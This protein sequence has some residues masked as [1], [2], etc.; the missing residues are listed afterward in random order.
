MARRRSTV[1]QRGIGRR[2]LL[3]RGLPAGVGLAA[4]LIAACGG[5]TKDSGGQASGGGT[6]TTGSATTTAEQPR[7]GGTLR[8]GWT[9]AYTDV[10]DPHVSLSQAGFIFS[11][12]GNNALRMNGEGTEVAGELIEKW[13]VPGDGTEM[14]LK[15][16]QG[17]K[18]HDKPPVSGRGFDA[19]DVAFNLMRI[20]GKVNPSEAARF[21]RRQTVE[22]MAKAEAVDPATV[23]VTFDR[24]VS[25]FLS[26]LADIRNQMIP[27]DFLDKG[28]KLEDGGALIGTGPFVIDSFKGDTRLEFKRNPNYWKP[29][30]PYVDGVVWQI[31]P[32]SLSLYTSFGKGDLDYTGYPLPT[33]TDRELIKRT[34]P[35]AREE[36]YISPSWNHFRFNATKKPFDD[37]RV[38]RAIHLALNYKTLSEPYY[39]DGYWDYTGLCPAA[40]PGALSPDEV[41]KLPGWNPNTKD[42]DIRTAKDLMTAAGYPDGALAFKILLGGPETNTSYYDFTIRAISQL[43]AVWPAMNP[44]I[45]PPADNATFSRRQASTDFEVIAYILAAYPDPV[46]EM[47]A[48]MLSTGSRNYGKF[49]DERVDRLLTNAAVQLDTK[50]RAATLNETQKLLNEELMP[51]IPINMSRMYIIAHP[52]VRGIPPSSYKALGSAFEVVRPAEQMWFAV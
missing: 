43:K 29:G 17:V 14:I 41:A 13:E 19:E 6:A 36:R 3:A 31:I 28:A 44:Q 4:A 8:Q 47:Q 50:Q 7:R 23:K 22:G 5:D 27:R 21:Q 46:L 51:L 37:A 18:W 35:N 1:D 25:T 2:R 33:R 42:A 24:P 32:D 26:G 39:G 30:L 45:D 34:A 40:L 52:K 48:H 20:G 12:I 49:K 38:R 9:R 10:F 11:L 16:R 15:V